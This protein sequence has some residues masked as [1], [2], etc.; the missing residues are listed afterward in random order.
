[1]PGATT[2]AAVQD[3][4]DGPA[5]LEAAAA[6]VGSSLDLDAPVLENITEDNAGRNEMFNETFSGNETVISI[7]PVLRWKRL[8]AASRA[9]RRDLV[10]VIRGFLKAVVADGEQ[11]FS[12]HTAEAAEIFDAA[13][14]AAAS[15]ARINSF[16]NVIASS[17]TAAIKL[18]LAGDA[19]AMP[20]HHFMNPPQDI[21]HA[22]GAAGIHFYEPSPATNPSGTMKST[23]WYSN[24]RL[25][26]KTVVG[27]A[28]LKGKEGSWLGNMTALHVGLDAG[29]NTFEADLIRLV[30]RT[31]VEA[32]NTP[33]P[34]ASAAAAEGGKVSNAKAKD[35]KALGVPYTGSMFLK[36]FVDFAFHGEH[37]DPF[38]EESHQGFFYNL[39][40]QKL[41]AE[42][43][44]SEPTPFHFVVRP[45]RDTLHVLGVVPAAV[46]E[47]V[48]RGGAAALAAAREHV[49][50]MA[51]SPRAAATAEVY[52]SLL[53]RL[54]ASVSGHGSNGERT[55]KERVAI[56]KDELLIA[57]RALG[58]ELEEI[59]KE[60]RASGTTDV[61][62]ARQ[63]GLYTNEVSGAL[64]LSYFLAYKYVAVT[65]IGLFH[66]THHVQSRVRVALLANANLGGDGTS[67]G[68][69][70]GA[71]LGTALGKTAVPTDLALGLA[72]HA[73]VS[74]ETA[75]FANV[76]QVGLGGGVSNHEGEL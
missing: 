40:E 1:M 56:L 55:A 66:G 54:L 68:S 31:A 76:I 42:R 6:T 11:A 45:S 62:A 35:Q 74:S 39:L 65:P 47:A 34:A 50:A 58:Y 7:D 27:P 44:A 49:T 8:T 67:R 53:L 21:A 71:V 41:P 19:L 10:P 4:V 24:D 72:A 28:V 63:F 43:C 16:A 25:A 51:A 26:I 61:D 20:A 29:E 75:E 22:I 9:D 36:A 64:V 30:L 57:G 3:V 52:A 32:S 48:P 5:L 18:A 38:L 12:A 14:I 15:G 33:T 70:I 60:T 37:K 23:Q 2:R 46:F 59:L 17:A 69:I 73:P 13:H